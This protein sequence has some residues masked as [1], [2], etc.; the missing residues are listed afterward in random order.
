MREDPSRGANATVW[1]LALLLLI[2]LP[3]TWSAPSQ[4]PTANSSAGAS[5]AQSA[6]SGVQPGSKA[7]AGK[8][9]ENS[10]KPLTA[11][12]IQGLVAGGV[13]SRRLA[14]LVDS[15]GIDFVPNAEFLNGLRAEGVSEVLIQAIQNAHPVTHGS[16]RGTHPSAATAEKSNAPEPNSPSM[17]STGAGTGAAAG[18]GSTARSDIRK[19]LE[20]DMARAAHFNLL[21]SWPEAEGIYRASLKLEPGSSSAHAGLATAL[22]GE[23]R[24]DDAI[25]EYREAVRLDS[26]NS[27]AQRGLARAFMEKHDW[28]NAIAEYRKALDPEPG[29]TELQIGYGDALYAKGDLNDAIGAYQAAKKLNPNDAAI[30]KALGLALYAS[31]DAEG[32]LAA[33]RDAD[34]LAPD[35]PELHKTIGDV[36]LSKGDRRGALEEYHRAFELAPD[37]STLGSS[38]AA[39]LKILSQP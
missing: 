6:P 18:A 26:T 3:V 37:D 15:R 27:I 7:S 2:P 39:I 32:A 20:Q 10:S 38:Y 19:A 35:D 12:Q 22:A 17:T 29:D 23:K 36:L 31:G 1:P 11:Q 5:G 16:K 21:Q 9:S 13:D 33:L 8:T 30:E 28:N 4:G 14:L 24:W 25:A 34:R